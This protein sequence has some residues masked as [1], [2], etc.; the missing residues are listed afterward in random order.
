MV[1]K[2]CADPGCNVLIEPNERYCKEHLK[3]NR[4]PFE[5]ATRFNEQL[6]AT[7]HWR[8]L[9]A[10]HLK[11]QPYC[12]KCGISKDE[13]PLQVHHI[14]PPGGNEE[15]FFDENNLAS[16]CPVCHR[17]ITQKETRQRIK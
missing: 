16:L 3:E 4:K 2:I 13:V 12:C 11:K 10:E 17:I 5:N 15:L 6:Y 8:K 9:R 1:K 7:S 14:I